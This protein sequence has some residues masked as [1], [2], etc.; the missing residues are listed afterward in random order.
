[1]SGSADRDPASRHARNSEPFLA[2]LP[3]GSVFYQDAITWDGKN[4][5]PAHRGPE[6]HCL[7]PETLAAAAEG[8]GSRG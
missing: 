6:V 1:V 5:R 8:N 2:R 7:E 4:G 3:A